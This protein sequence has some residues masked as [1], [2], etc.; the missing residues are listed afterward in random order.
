MKEEIN[1]RL[2]WI[3]GIDIK[4]NQLESPICGLDLEE[5]CRCEDFGGAGGLARRA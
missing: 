5:R 2:H 4:V 1:L 3:E